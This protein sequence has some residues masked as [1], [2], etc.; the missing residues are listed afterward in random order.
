[1]QIGLA[2]KGAHLFPLRLSLQSVEFLLFHF[3]QLFHL[4]FSHHHFGLIFPILTNSMMRKNSLHETHRTFGGP[5]KYNFDIK[6]IGREDSPV[7][8]N[9]MKKMDGGFVLEIASETD[10]EVELR[11]SRPVWT[12]G[13][14]P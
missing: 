6:G 5:K 8:R 4:S 9:N 2:K 13:V 7:D 14:S 3:C 10:T 12:C 1:M 11:R